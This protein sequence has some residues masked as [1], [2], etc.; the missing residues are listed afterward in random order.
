MSDRQQQFLNW[1]LGVAAGLVL[2]AVSGGILFDRDIAR[3]V[4]DQGARI[5]N[6]EN[7]I[8][9][10]RADRRAE[11]GYRDQA[12]KSLENRVDRVEG[13]SQRGPR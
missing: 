13:G 5:R 7:Q 1:V 4:S 6:I 9:A 10:Y 8:D 11:L 12:I 2:L 3:E